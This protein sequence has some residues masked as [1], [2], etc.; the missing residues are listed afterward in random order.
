MAAIYTVTNAVTQWDQN[1]VNQ[2][3]TVLSTTLGITTTTQD[4]LGRIVL[5]SAA[6]NPGSPSNFQTWFRTDLGVGGRL[7]MRHSN[8]QSVPYL[9]LRQRV[10]AANS[11]GSAAISSTSYADITNATLD[12]V[13]TGGRLLIYLIPEDGQPANITFGS[14]AASTGVTFG[15]IKALIGATSLGS[16]RLSGITNFDFNGIVGGNVGSGISGLLT[17]I[18]VGALVWDYKPAAGTYTVK[19]QGKVDASAATWTI[20]VYY[21]RLVVIEYGD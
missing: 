10:E 12:I 3:A 16:H 7:H 19:L 1:D 21:A 13:T 11:T 8:G 17:N 14:S 4:A 15:D 6:A 20:Y 5:P 18:P 9:P 2:Y